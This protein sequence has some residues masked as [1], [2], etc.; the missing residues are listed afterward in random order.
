MFTGDWMWPWVQPEYI[1]HVS[2]TKY[3]PVTG[4][5]DW[6]VSGVL[7][8]VK[9]PVLSP[10]LEVQLTGVVAGRRRRMGVV[11]SP[12][13]GSCVITVDGQGNLVRVQSPPTLV[14]SGSD[15]NVLWPSV[16]VR[17]WSLVVAWCP[18]LDGTGH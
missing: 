10:G 6:V 18:W 17:G 15:F 12:P 9:I 8:P 2:G 14:A 11:G 5:S 16:Q 3:F 1:T 13:Y 4:C 7:R